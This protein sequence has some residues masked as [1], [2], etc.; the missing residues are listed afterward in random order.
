MKRRD[1]EAVG[2]VVRFFLRR[3]G[4]ET[5]LNEQ[6]LIDAWPK[7]LGA[8]AKYTTQ[9]QIY[10]QVLHVSLSSSVLRNELMMRRAALVGELNRLVGATVITN[11]VFH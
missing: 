11:I 7:L 3:N 1:P 2:D 9:I 6:R 8:A 10:N 5:P 4:L